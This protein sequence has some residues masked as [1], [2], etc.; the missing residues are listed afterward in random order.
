MKFPWKTPRAD[1]VVGQQFNMANVWRYIVRSVQGDSHLAD[2]TPCQD[3][4]RVQ[5]LTSSLAGTLVACV[6]D[7]AGSAKHS[8]IGSLVACN[9]LVE[10]IDAY[11]Q[12]HRSITEVDNRVI[13]EW[14]S[15]ARLAIEVEANARE[16]VLTDFA[17]TLEVAVLTSTGSCFF[18]IGDGAIVLHH[19]SVWG[20]VFWPESGEYFNTTTF[21]T[22]KEFRERLQWYV[23]PV[24]FDEV[25]LFTDGIE[26]LALRFDSQTPH[27]PFFA[28]LFQALRSVPDWQ[29][30][31]DNLEAFLRSES[32]RKRSDDDKTLILAARIHE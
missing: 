27:T 17:T 15:Q 6:A 4:N 2:G 13:L 3:S 12:A 11:L 5:V 31:G 14:C 21:I 30:L 9:S 16:A 29:N 8:A 10:S 18:Q 28:P 23:T 1:R 25:A 7:G 20:V 24:V 26:R 22:S 19:H 32:V